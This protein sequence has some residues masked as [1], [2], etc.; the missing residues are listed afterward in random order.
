M[1]LWAVLRAEEN[2]MRG[3]FRYKMTVWVFAKFRLYKYSK[4]NDF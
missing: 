1:S 4:I 2:K 3:H